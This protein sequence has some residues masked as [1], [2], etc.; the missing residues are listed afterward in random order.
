MEVRKTNKKLD[1]LKKNNHLESPFISRIEQF[2]DNYV[3]YHNEGHYST[4]MEISNPILQYSGNANLY[5]EYHRTFLN[6]SKILGENYILQKQDIFFDAKYKGKQTE[7][8]LSQ[9]YFQH[10]EGRKYKDVKTYLTI[11]RK[12]KRGNF[13]TYNEKYFESFLIKIR[14]VSDV[15]K[16]AKFNPKPLNER[17]ITFLLKRFFS[18]CFDTENIK[19]DNFFAGDSDLKI[20]NKHLKT[21]PLIDIDE[22][23]FPNKI[24]PYS[25]ENL[26]YNFPVDL[27]SFIANVPDVETIV[28]NQ[29]ISISNQKKELMDLEKKK[30]RHSSV[31]DPQNEMAVTDIDNALAKIAQDNDLLINSHFSF[32]IFGTEDANVNA[33]N[34]IEQALFKSRD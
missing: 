27:F 8:F 10:F 6:I 34:Y 4:L 25:T 23:N 13:F 26:G 16:E 7:D 32:M 19:F 15:L 24:K 11:T 22:I 31:P 2:N 3:L 18:F 21:I 30:K 14:K 20:R 29:V 17:E 12:I 5:Y 1:I 33:S 9:K 28:Y